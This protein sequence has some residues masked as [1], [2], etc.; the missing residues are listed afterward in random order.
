MALLINDEGQIRL[1]RWFLFVAAHTGKCE[2]GNCQGSGQP[3][4]PGPATIPSFRAKRSRRKAETEREEKSHAVTFPLWAGR[5]RLLPVF[6]DIDS[7]IVLSFN[8][9]VQQFD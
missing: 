2:P 8:V 5:R 6:I 1:R 9:A 7:M 4:H 3:K